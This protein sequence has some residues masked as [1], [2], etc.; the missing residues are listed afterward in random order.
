MSTLRLALHEL[1][2]SGKL[3][4]AGEIKVSTMGQRKLKRA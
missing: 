4:G 2:I 1:R 3:G